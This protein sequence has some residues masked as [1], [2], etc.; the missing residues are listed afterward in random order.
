MLSNSHLRASRNLEKSRT[1]AA[2][3]TGVTYA[4]SNSAVC[5]IIVANRAYARAALAVALAHPP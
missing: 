2:H 5:D 3:L 1:L 4:A